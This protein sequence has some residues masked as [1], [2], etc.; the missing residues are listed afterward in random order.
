MTRSE[1]LIEEP[2]PL[3]TLTS[4]G[5]THTE[6]KGFLSRIENAFAPHQTKIVRYRQLKRNSFPYEGVLM[7]VWAYA[8]TVW[9]YVVA[10]QL[11]FPDSPYWPLARW[12]PIRMDYLGELCFLF[13]FMLAC[14]LSVKYLRSRG[15]K[16]P[17]T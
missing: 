15:M 11:R 10:M 9:V 17:Q 7:A 1:E 3:E 13:S 4:I 5:F 8:F 12:L 2:T 6:A 16:S 14:I